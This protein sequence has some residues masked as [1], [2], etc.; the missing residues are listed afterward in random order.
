[1]AAKTLS[2]I[3]LPLV[4][5]AASGAYVWDQARKGPAMPAAVADSVATRQPVPFVMRGSTVAR[6]P[7]MSTAG[8]S[9][10][11]VGP[12][13]KPI[14]PMPSQLPVM[15]VA[16]HTGYTDGSYTGPV[17]D[18]YYG[19]VQVQAIVQGGRL[20]GINVLQYP[21]DRRTSVVINR[22][23]LPM[24]RD[25]VISAQSANVDIVSGATLTS[26][27]FIRSLDS[28]LSQASA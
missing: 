15:T 5:I 3:I 23:A 1:M 18:A 2:K 13:Q 21:S 12:A 7:G 27:A 26:E 10:A 8:A 25:E 28:A 9:L 14:A 11:A 4:V 17:A 16:A 22:Q 20:A 6:D 19:V 24:L